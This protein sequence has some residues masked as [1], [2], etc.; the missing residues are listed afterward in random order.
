M[1]IRR[2][3]AASQS[4]LAAINGSS[5][6][7]AAV[8]LGKQL[9][10]SYVVTGTVEEYT[11]RGGDGFGRLILRTRLIEVATG[12]VTHAD[13]TAQRSTS[14]MSTKGDAEMHTKTV[15]SALDKVTGALAE[16][17]Y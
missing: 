13:E 16:L 12:K 14:A 1:D 5:S 9:G 10:V 15:P 17:R 2:T 3:R 7:A 4:D 11:P 6:T 8:K